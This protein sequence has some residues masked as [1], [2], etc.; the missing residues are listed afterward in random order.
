MIS[1]FLSILN[2]W[3]IIIPVYIVMIIVTYVYA[4][5]KYPED[6]RKSAVFCAFLWPLAWIV[7]LPGFIVS[8]VMNIGDSI[9]NRFTETEKDEN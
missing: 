1:F 4:M 7:E 9:I 5:V 2:K 6:G 8:L 3:M